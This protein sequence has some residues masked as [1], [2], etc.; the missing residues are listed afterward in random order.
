MASREQW[1]NSER[2]MAA[3]LGYR[4]VPRNEPRLRQRISAQSQPRF[5]TPI[6][7]PGLPC[8]RDAGPS[9]QGPLSA[10]RRLEVA[11]V[12]LGRFEAPLAILAWSTT[13]CLPQSAP[14]ASTTMDEKESIFA[15]ARRS[16]CPSWLRASLSSIAHLGRCSAAPKSL[17]NCDR[18]G[19]YIPGIGMISTISTHAPDICRWGWSL[20]NIFVA[21][22]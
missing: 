19:V 5:C 3:L 10:V 9:P 1:A 2:S 6:S 15:P 22:S 8:P 13:S 21:A 16:D 7:R 4:V 11:Q 18:R 12:D 17:L 14:T 20:P